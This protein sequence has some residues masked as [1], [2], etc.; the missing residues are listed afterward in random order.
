MTQFLQAVLSGILVGGVL[1]LVSMGLSLV[2]GVVRII[3]FAHGDLVML[4]MYGTFLLY[5]GMTIFPPFSVLI[6]APPLF[7]FGA[8]LYR[9]LFEPVVTG[10]TELLP[11]L[12]LTVGIS[13]ALQTIAQ[14]VFSPTQRSIQMSWATTYYHVGEVF[15]NQAQVIAFLVSLAVSLLLWLFLART[16]LGRAM[17]AIVDDREVAQ[18]MGINSRRIYA[19]AV[20]TSA[21]LAAVGGN[22]LMTYY[23]A[24]PVVGLQFLPL[25]F[26]AVVMGGMGNVMG[27]FL[28][29]II[30]GIVQ[31]VTGVYV[32]FQLQNAGLLLV[33]ILILLLRP[34]GLFGKEGSL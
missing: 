28:G 27:A 9:V 29:G 10:S 21:A 24:F 31:Q 15:I 6:V 7:L 20:G 8:L 3:N 14:W 18:M 34:S 16:D 26:V 13:F 4:S 11:Q 30:V 1:G 2:F 22:I 19:I 5:T 33:F 17:R 23:P 12:S 25:A 32:A